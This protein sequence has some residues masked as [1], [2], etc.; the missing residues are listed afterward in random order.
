MKNIITKIAIAFLVITMLGGNLAPICAYAT[1]RVAE[2]TTQEITGL[3]INLESYIHK[4]YETLE[5]AEDGSTIV[6]T[7]YLKNNTQVAKTLQIRAN[8]SNSTLN[9]KAIVRICDVEDIVEEG[10]TYKGLLEERRLTISYKGTFRINVAPN[11]E[12]AVKIEQELANNLY[13]TI[14]NSFTITNKNQKIVLEDEKRVSKS[15]PDLRVVVQEEEKN[16]I[17]NQ[18]KYTIANDK[19]NVAIKGEQNILD[20][21]GDT[22]FNGQKKDG[23][24]ITR[25]G[26]ENLGERVVINFSK[27]F[28]HDKEMYCANCDTT[29]YKRFWIRNFYSIYNAELYKYDKTTATLLKDE[30]GVASEYK[31]TE[32]MY[33]KLAYIFSEIDNYNSQAFYESQGIN[34]KFDGDRPDHRIS[35]IQIAIWKVQGVSVERIIERMEKRLKQLGVSASEIPTIAN[36]ILGTGM[37]IYANAVAYDQYVKEGSIAKKPQINIQEYNTIQVNGKTLIGPFSV[38]YENV[39]RATVTYKDATN[40]TIEKIGRYGEVVEAK[41][42]NNGTEYKDIYDEKGDQI[43]L[44][45]TTE[46]P[47]KCYFNITDGNF[48]I[49]ETTNMGIKMNN[50]YRQSYFYTLESQY[51]GQNIIV[52]NGTSS[53]GEYEVQFDSK[54]ITLNGKVWLDIPQGIKPMVPPNGKIDENEKG[55]KDVEVSLFSNSKSQVIATV[56][57]DKEGN[58]EFKDV[59]QDEYSIIFGYEGIKHIAVDTNGDSKAI[60]NFTI[61][62]KDIRTN[63]NEK[64]TQ[65][66]K[67]K[68]I[69]TKYVL[70]TNGNVVEEPTN[71]TMQYQTTENPQ[72]GNA[73]SELITGAAGEIVPAYKMFAKTINSYNETTN[74]INLGLKAREGDLSLSTDMAEVTLPRTSGRQKKL[75][76]VNYTIGQKETLVTYKVDLNNQLSTSAQTNSIIY[77]YDSELEYIPSSAEY[78]Y[79]ENGTL[80]TTKDIIV[81]Q[82]EV[83]TIGRK[84]YNTLN[85]SGLDV[86]TLNEGERATVYLTFKVKSKKAEKQKLTTF[87]EITS[88]TIEGGIVDS[89]SAPGNGIKENASILNEDDFSECSTTVLQFITRLMIKEMFNKFDSIN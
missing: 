65:I 76:G 75:A 12:K 82:G 36:N 18:N 29:Y 4:N 7:I 38:N 13:K 16:E 3:D 78:T 39:Q 5:N 26:I 74:N 87:G 20:I 23:A 55:I 72:T 41:I 27:L 19:F 86:A 24:P 35:P 88:Y 22:S 83:I 53:L 60:E 56:S 59:A 81:E 89:D 58:Y 71:W 1:A 31:I 73:K 62:N 67:D 64:F 46:N 6:S 21:F 70:T 25:F 28:V 2:K 80:Q 51:Q 84:Q 54:T 47:L 45:T 49:K 44:E 10:E 34:F 68:K 69:T 77:Y 42:T 32:E 33:N 40:A 50:Q 9:K 8:M 11:E 37:Q 30:Q 52:G 43:N 63:F 79:N 14:E 15:T 17:E 66:V 61:N 85:I 57:T 48:D